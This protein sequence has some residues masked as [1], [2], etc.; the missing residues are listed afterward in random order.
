MLFEA[1]VMT[2]TLLI[3]FPIAFQ[4][5]RGRQRDTFIIPDQPLSLREEHL[6]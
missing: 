6:T 4:L 2:I 5:P 1:P 3:R